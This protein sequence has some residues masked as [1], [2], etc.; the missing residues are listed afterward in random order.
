MKTPQSMKIL[1]WIP[2]GF[3]VFDYITGIELRL[4]DKFTVLHLK[5]DPKVKPNYIGLEISK[6]YIEEFEA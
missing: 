5:E 6:I 3:K 1:K 4:G 2:P